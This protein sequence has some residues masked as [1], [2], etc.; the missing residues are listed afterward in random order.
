MLWGSRGLFHFGSCHAA[1]RSRVNGPRRSQAARPLEAWGFQGSFYPHPQPRH[2]EPSGRRSARPRFTVRKGCRSYPPTGNSCSCIT[3]QANTAPCSAAQV[4][5]IGCS[6]QGWPLPADVP[7][8]CEAGSCMASTSPCRCGLDSTL[9]GAGVA[10]ACSP[11]QAPCV[12]SFGPGQCECLG[13]TDCSRIDSSVAECS[14]STQ[15]LCP[16]VCQAVE[17][18]LGRRAA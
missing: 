9:D 6:V 11:Q 13:A 7:C 2:R 3:G 5:G 17:E 8:S 10:T 12:A 1:R 18:G 4:G 15:G 14:P 16:A